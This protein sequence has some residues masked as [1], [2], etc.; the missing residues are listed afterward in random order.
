[1]FWFSDMGGRWLNSV[2]QKFSGDV[3]IWT[4]QRQEGISVLTTGT[5]ITPYYV[6]NLFII[7]AYYIAI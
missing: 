7:P 2:G 3:A 6:I 5:F 1:M 4:A